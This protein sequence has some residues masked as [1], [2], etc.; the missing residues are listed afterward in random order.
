MY[1]E[2]Y[3]FKTPL[4]IALASDGMGNFD[5]NGRTNKSPIEER[6]LFRLLVLPF[7]RFD[8]AEEPLLELRVGGPYWQ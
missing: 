2:P 7:F 1:I 3:L 8:G 5:K 4:W 6:W